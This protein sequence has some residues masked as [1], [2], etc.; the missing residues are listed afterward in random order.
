MIDDRRCGTC[1]H[2]DS[3]GDGYRGSK[4]EWG[5]CNAPVPDCVDSGFR[6]EI[7]ASAGTTCPCW[8]AKQ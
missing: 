5:W 8:E 3:G 2:Y 4:K 6:D 1:R 7:L